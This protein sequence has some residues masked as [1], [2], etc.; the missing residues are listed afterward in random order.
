M[1][2]MGVIAG[3]VTDIDPANFADAACG[4]EFYNV[5]AH[6]SVNATDPGPRLA[7]VKHA[8]LAPLP[9]LQPSG[10]SVGDGNCAWSTS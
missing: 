9:S 10:L 4:T 7:E 1:I 8:V 6:G 3:Y 2:P 5:K